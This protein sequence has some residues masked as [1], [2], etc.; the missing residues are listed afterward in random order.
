MLDS[1]NLPKQLLPALIFCEN[2]QFI[3][4][5]RLVMSFLLRNVLSKKNKQIMHFTFS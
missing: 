4:L 3:V 2:I 1:W 5:E